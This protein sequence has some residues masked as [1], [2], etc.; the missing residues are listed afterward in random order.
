VTPHTTPTE[1]T[2]TLLREVIS[3]SNASE[4]ETCFAHFK[5]Q[6]E[7]AGALPQHTRARY[8]ANTCRIPT[9][10]GS[11]EYAV[12]VLRY[13]IESDSAPDLM[14]YFVLS[15]TQLPYIYT[16]YGLEFLQQLESISL[17]SRHHHSHVKGIYE[18][19]TSSALPAPGSNGII[20]DTSLRLLIRGLWDVTRTEEKLVPRSVAASLR[21]LAMKISGQ[22][23]RQNLVRILDNPNDTAHRIAKLVTV[24]RD[25]ILPVAAVDLLDHIPRKLMHIW[26]PSLPA[27]LSK[28]RSA[29]RHSILWLRLSHSLDCVNQQCSEEASLSG[30]AFKQ[31]TKHYL[32]KDGVV[33]FPRLVILALL[34]HLLRHKSFANVDTERMYTFIKDHLSDIYF[35]RGFNGSLVRLIALLHEASLPNHGVL[36]LMVPSIAQARGTHGIHSVVQLLRLIAKS[37]LTLTDTAFLGT[38]VS[39]SMQEVGAAKSLTIRE[40]QRYAFDLKQCQHLETIAQSLGVRTSAYLSSLQEDRQFL[41]ILD[42]ASHSGVVPLAYRKPD[43][44]IPMDERVAFIHQIAHQ[45][46]LDRTRTHRQNWRSLSYLYR[47]LVNHNYPI[48]TL[49]S[50]AIVRVGIIQP[51]SGND[52]VSARRLRLICRIVEEA[53]GEDVARKIE[54][55]FWVWRGDLIKNAQNT[56]VGVGQ[57]GS[58]HIR[59]LKRLKMF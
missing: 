13:F 42:R 47:Y 48:G 39:Q 14:H 36:E 26:A 10:D 38:F 37:D 58:A 11:G 7:S 15:H 41:H 46:S 4:I 30:V 21:E 55:I 51:T 20:Q 22:Y 40:R 35:N 31:L 44:V 8:L 49:M 34:Y 56:L 3:K 5:I 17:K 18:K 23:V 57:Y 45:Y 9:D 29:T 19:L 25:D 43:R 53:E 59:T 50:H 1:Q 24:C 32:D 52:F 6:I 33:V 28:S 27:L 12:R 2:S 16:E 54:H